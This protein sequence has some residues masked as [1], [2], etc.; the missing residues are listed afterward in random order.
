MSGFN[1][2]D[3]EPNLPYVDD[4]DKSMSNCMKL[5]ILILVI[6]AIILYIVLIWKE[7]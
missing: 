5:E 6:M 2:F 7:I 1:N 4:I 3:E